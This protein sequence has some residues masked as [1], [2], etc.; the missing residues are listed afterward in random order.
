MII[1]L[2]NF[3]NS[4]KYKLPSHG[5]PAGHRAGRHPRARRGGIQKAGRRR[6]VQGRGGAAQVHPPQAFTK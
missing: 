6:L 2:G 3:L 4:Q 1:L 5:P